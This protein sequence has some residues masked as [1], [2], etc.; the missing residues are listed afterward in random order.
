[1]R[2]MFAVALVA[3]MSFVAFATASPAQAVR[4]DFYMGVDVGTLAEVEAAGERFYDDGVQ[5]DALQIMADSGANLVRLRLWNDPYSTS[6]QAYGGGTNDLEKTIELAQRAKDL[7]MD[8]LLD[9]HYSDFWADPG[10]QIKPK[11]WQSL[12][13]NQLVTAVRDYSRDVVS[14]MTAAGATPDIVQVGN[15]ITHGMLQPTGSTSNWNQLGGLLKAGIEGVHAGGSGIEIAL[16][17]DRGGNNGAYRTWFDNARAQGVPYDIIALSYYPYWHGTMSQLRNNMNDVASRYGKD[18]MVVETAYAWTL[19][20]GD[21]RGNIFTSSHAQESGYAAT[22]QGQTQF[23]RDLQDAIADV[24]NDRGRGLVWWEAAWTG[25]TSWATPAGMSYINDHAGESNSWDNQTLFDHNGNKLSTL[26]FF[27]EVTGGGDPGP[28]PGQDELTNGGFESGSGRSAT[29]WNVWAQN[30]ADSDAVFR[31]TRGSI[32]QGTSKLTFWKG[33]A[34]T[35]SAY[36]SQSVPNG[37]YTLT[38]WVMNGGGQTTARM[39]AKGYGGSERQANLP[40]TSQW[41]KVSITGVQVTS[42]RIEVGF[43][44]VA[45]AGNWI[46]IDAVSLTR[47]A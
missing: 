21:G 35:A 25:D 31:E 4:D 3:A 28:G 22:V 15:E 34:Y 27:G 12:S 38:A 26:D 20:D 16:H 33:S 36:Q 43:Y 1:M 18:V 14:Q 5:G 8:V 40:V 46:N 9:L 24:P 13:Y 39:Y 10:K 32:Y 6:G 17:L 30:S 47:T 29:G 19:Q 37:T 7:G 42:G 11:A 44:S 2:R 45:R 23:L 41:T